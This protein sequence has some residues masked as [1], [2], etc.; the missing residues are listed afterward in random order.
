MPDFLPGG[1]GGGGGGSG[2]GL[3]PLVC[4]VGWSAANFL[5]SATNRL[6]GANRTTAV[7]L[8]RTALVQPGG[9]PQT[10]ISSGDRF[11]EGYAMW[12]AGDRTAIQT[13]T[14]TKFAIE[15]PPWYAP[16]GGTA[17]V[18]PQLDYKTAVFTM[19]LNHADAPYLCSTRMQFL[20]QSNNTD[21][22]FVPGTSGMWVGRQTNNVD[23]F[24]GGIAAIAF[25]QAAALTDDQLATIIRR[26]RVIS[27]LDNQSGLFTNLWSFKTMGL[28]NGQ[29]LPA[30]IPD[31]V[32]DA[33]LAHTGALTAS[34]ETPFWV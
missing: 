6:N 18:W 29:T 9:D 33:P 30:S 19:R 10:L 1:G 28:T 13:S 17:A 4:A 34:E 24:L 26:A 11:F 2:G 3:P 32:G 20:G 31:Q 22:T 25:T 27:D 12:V 7:V 14:G 23:H 8:A 15:G 21:P 5:R 16:A